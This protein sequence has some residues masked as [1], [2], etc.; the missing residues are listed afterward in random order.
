MENILLAAKLR[1]SS[2]KGV[3]RQLRMKGRVPGVFY[4]KN[5]ENIPFD[6]E[7]Y[8]L[9]KL[10]RARPS[11]INLE[12]GDQDPR[13]CVFREMQLD[14]VNEEILH[15]DLMGFKRGQ[16]LTITVPVRLIGVP[17]GVKNEGGILQHGTTELEI[18]CMPRH[19]PSSI[20]L[21]VSELIIGDA[22]H[23]GDL[24][25][26][27]FKFFAD[28]QVVVAMVSEPALLKEDIEEEEEEEGD[29]EATESSEEETDK[30]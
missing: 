13:E 14:P 30:G 19:I 23:I 11:L 7:R 3:A 10:L 27:N 18:E 28:E 5:E 1:T 25:Y 29:E 4:L 26:P 2:G 17:K 22:I 16:K 8:D 20:N 24:D 6:V 21:D 15:I 12:I 9:L